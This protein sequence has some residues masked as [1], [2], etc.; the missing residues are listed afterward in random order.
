MSNIEVIRIG[1]IIEKKH[2]VRFNK[3][4]VYDV[5]DSSHLKLHIKN[6]ITN[7]HDYYNKHIEINVTNISNISISSIKNINDSDLIRVIIDRANFS[8]LKRLFFNN[9][10][11]TR[12][13]ITKLIELIDLYN[14]NK[15][16]SISNINSISDSKLTHISFINSS[17][18]DNDIK[19]LNKITN[20]KHIEILNFYNTKLNLDFYINLFFDLKTNYYIKELY[21]SNTYKETKTHLRIDFEF[22]SFNTTL[23]VLN[24]S[25]N[26]LNDK[27][28]LNL[29]HYLKDNHTIKELNISSKS[30]N[31]YNIRSRRNGAISKIRKMSDISE[32][33]TNSNVN[34][35]FNK[36]IDIDEDTSNLNNE[37]N[38]SLVNRHLNYIIDANS[39]GAKHYNIT[40]KYTN[41][42]VQRITF[43]SIKELLICSS[44][45]LINKL[46][47]SVFLKDLNEKK[48]FLNLLALYISSSNTVTTLIVNIT[49]I[50]KRNEEVKEKYVSFCIYYKRLILALKLNRSINYFSI[51]GTVL[52]NN[53][54]FRYFSKFE[55]D[56][57]D[58]N[59]INDSINFKYDENNSFLEYVNLLN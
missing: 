20:I 52:K 32:K 31:S 2:I 49:S 46:E 57:Y 22:I 36:D 15:N 29:V 54:I 35:T 53:Q 56:S 11:W 8:S 13:T 26:N 25:N 40:F 58:I 30:C 28:I 42:E 12:K 9:I 45:I 55:K 10:I 6:L 44:I 1:D 47:F 39:I 24:L 51:N 18:L 38:L 59:K 23:T 17:L 14:N 19:E 7:K 43:K 21:L 50:L 3:L 37:A 48:E 5:N 27:N 34:I 16:D 33:K 4:A 41:L